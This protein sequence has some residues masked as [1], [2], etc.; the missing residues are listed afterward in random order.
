MTN[1]RFATYYVAILIILIVGVAFFSW[2]G[3]MF[4][5][6]IESILSAKGLRWIL[7][8]F[9]DNSLRSDILGYILVGLF[10]Y[11]TLVESE[12]LRD[13]GAFMFPRHIHRTLSLKRRRALILTHAMLLLYIVCVAASI[14]F[15]HA[16]FLSVNGTIEDSAFSKGLFGII[17]FAI[18]VSGLIYGLS[19]GRYRSGAD[20]IESATVTIHRNAYYFII[21]FL[22]SQ[23]IS[24]TLHVGLYDMI[25]ITD[26]AKDVVIKLLYLYP[27]ARLIVKRR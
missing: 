5:Q 4:G 3:S 23:L 8:S 26:E 1:K 12:I 21:Y 19:I 22:A 18:F 15:P 6:P 9:I 13:M 16:I 7:S 20:I 24:L 2:I 14:L 25:P 17:A 10:A 11:D 27:L